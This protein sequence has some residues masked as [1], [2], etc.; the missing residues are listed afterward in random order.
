M[1]SHWPILVNLLT[2]SLVGAWLGAGW[3]LRLR[4]ERLYKVIA[5]LL[6]LIETVRLA[7]TC[8]ASHV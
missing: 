5:I 3:A 2:G 8:H 6:V 4:S 7:K 1:L